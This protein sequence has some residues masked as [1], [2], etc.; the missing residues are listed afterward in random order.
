MGPPQI[1]HHGTPI[2][3]MRLA[4]VRNDRDG[5][6]VVMADGIELGSVPDRMLLLGVR[7]VEIDWVALRASM[8]LP[9]T[10]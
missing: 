8:G 9:A 4:S 5:E 6:Y 1:R 7:A 10:G 2:P 3:G